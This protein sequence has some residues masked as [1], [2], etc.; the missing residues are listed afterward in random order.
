MTQDMKAG[1]ASNLINQIYK[2]SG[3]QGFFKGVSFRCGILC[4]GGIVYFGAL[5]KARHF[6]EVQ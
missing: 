2:E 3:I 1:S 5:Q 6:L 4:F